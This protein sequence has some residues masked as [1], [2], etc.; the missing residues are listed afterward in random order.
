MPPMDVLARLRDVHPSSANYA[1]MPE[2]EQFVATLARVKMLP[3]RVD[4][5]VF[6]C[7]FD[8]LVREL[9]PV[10]RFCTR[11]L[12]TVN[13]SMQDIVA[14]TTACQEIRTSK[15]FAAFLELTLLT[16]NYMQA[17]T[18]NHK[19]VYAFNLSNLNNVC[20]HIAVIAIAFEMCYLYF[21]VQLSSTKSQDGQT[22]L[23]HFLCMRLEQTI[24]TDAANFVEH[25]WL[26]LAAATRVELQ[27]L[28]KQIANLKAI[29]SKVCSCIIIIVKSKTQD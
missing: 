11:V 12:M 16:G 8:E 13:I 15:S 3:A 29:V 25:D 21:A 23:L 4:A 17:S 9:K 14:V 19:L 2:G 24:G 5:L 20:E 28:A 18:K 10:R 7:R 27:E 6:M 22:T 26:H 1:S